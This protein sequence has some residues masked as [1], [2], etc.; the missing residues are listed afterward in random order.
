MNDIFSL[1]GDKTLSKILIEPFT[2]LSVKP[3]FEDVIE[4]YSLLG[5]SVILSLWL[6]IKSID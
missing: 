6:K 5:S 2:I 4:K 1:D 3:S